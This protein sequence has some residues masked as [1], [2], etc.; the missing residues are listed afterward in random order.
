MFE[1]LYR[2]MA[3]EAE[4]DFNALFGDTFLKAYQQYVDQLESQAGS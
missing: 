3:S 2:G 1:E 4:E